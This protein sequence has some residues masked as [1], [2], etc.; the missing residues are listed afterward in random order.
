MRLL[1]C[2]CLECVNFLAVPLYEYM[3]FF[4]KTLF[5]LCVHPYKFLVEYFLLREHLVI[6]Y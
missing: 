4:I 1:K 5:K 6:N 3:Y 2:V